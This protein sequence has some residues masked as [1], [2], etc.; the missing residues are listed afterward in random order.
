MSE[1]VPVE[2]PDLSGH[3]NTDPPAGTGTGTG[4]TKV[5][6]H[7][8]TIDL[9]RDALL[10]DFA[11]DLL[12][13]YYM[14]DDEGSPQEAFARAA[15]AYCYGDYDF[16]QRIYDYVSKGWFMFAS[17]VLSNAPRPGD[18]W[19]AL[20]ISCFVA[21]T[22]VMTEAS[23]KNIEDIQPGDM[24]WTHKGRLR[25]VVATRESDS[26]DLYRVIVNGRR[27]PLTVTGNHLLLT[28]LGWVRVDA[29]DVMKHLVAC[30]HTI[31]SPEESHTID[32]L[33]TNTPYTQFKR[34]Q[35]S[36][37]VDVSEDL[38]WALGFWF[39]E[40]SAH[41]NGTVSVT[42][43]DMDPCVRWSNIMSDH[44]GVRGVAEAYRTW[45]TG[46]VCSKTLQEW[47]DAEFGKGCTRKVLAPWI[48]RLP[49]GH[50]KA[51]YDGFYLG[52]GWKTSKHRAVEV[53]N[54][55][56][57]AGVHQ[58]LMKLGIDHTLQ[59]RKRTR[60]PSTVPYNGIIVERNTSGERRHHSIKKGIVFHDGLEYN[61]IQSIEKLD[62][63]AK[64]YD[65]QVEE[66]ESFIAAGVVAHNCFLTY[67]PDSLEGLIE[68]TSELRWLSVKGGGVGGHWSSV[69][70]VSK[71]SPGP[72]PFLK[73][74]DADMTAYRQ[75]TCY[76]PDTEVMTEHGWVRFD[77][78][79]PGVKVA[80]VTPDL[81]VVF[82]L[83]LELVVEDH[84]GDILNVRTPNGSVDLMVT[85]NH[86]M[87]IEQRVRAEGKK[88]WSGVL[89]KRRA[90]EL[91][92][93]ADV[94]FHTSARSSSTGPDV[95][96]PEERFRIAFQ[97]DGH[98]HARGGGCSFHLKK[99]R[100]IERVREILDACGYSY[101]EVDAPDGSVRFYVHAPVTGDKTFAW[102]DLAN[103]SPEWGA[104]FL[105]ELR[106]WDATSRGDGLAGFTYL[107][108]DKG[109]A[110]VVQAVA[111]L[112]GR[113]SRM[114]VREASGTRKDLWK[115]Y[116]RPNQHLTLQKVDVTPS[117]YEGK[118][119]CATV[120]TGMLLVRRSGVVTVC[121]N[122]RKGSYAAYLDVSH[123]DILEFLQ[124][125]LPTGGDPNRKCLNLHNAVNITDDFM[126][127]CVN[128][129]DWHLR[130][131][132]D[133]T[134]RETMPAR[135][136]FQR[137]LEVRFRTGEPYLNFIDTA[138]RALP[139]PLKDKGL[140]I[141]GSNLC[142]AG[143]Q[144]VV[145]DRGLLTARELYEQGGDLTVFDNNLSQKSSAMLL[146]EQ[147]TPV[148]RITLKNGM[149]HT[150]TEYHK[151][152]TDRGD[153]RCDDLV[154]G[155]RVHVQT[156]KGLFG[157]V[158]MEDEAFLLGLYQADGTQHEASLM[159]MIDLWEPDFDLIPEVQERFDRVHHKYGCDT[160]EVRN[161]TGDV[162][163]S[164]P[165]DPAR[166]RDQNTSCSDV[167]KVR[168]SSR[169]FH[170]SGL[171]F[172]KGLV[173][174]WIWSSDEATQWQYI[175]GLFYAD[176]TVN[177]G[178]GKGAPVYLSL[179][180]I[181]K[182]FL[183]DIL[184][185]LRNLGMSASLYLHRKSG[186]VMLPDGKGSH[187]PYE[188]K[189]AWRIVIG[190]K[191]DALAFE[192]A[193]G[194]LTRKGVKIPRRKYRNNS[195][196]VS[197]VVSVEAVGT[198]D[199]FCVNVDSEDHHF[200][201]NGMVTHNCSEIH[202]ATSEDRTAVC[203]LSSLNLARFDEWEGTPLVRDLIR[204]LDNVLQVFI[205]N[206]P[207]EL[208]RARYSATRERSLGLGAMGF[209]SYLQSK[210]LPWESALAKME[211]MRV[212]SHIQSEAIAATEQLAEERGEYPDG[213]GSGRR[214]SHLLAIAPNANSSII[215]GISPSIETWKSN[216][217]THRTRAG[218]HQVRNPELVKILDA[219]IADEAGRERIWSSIT[220]NQG[221][222]QHL[223]DEVITEWE[224]EVFKTA[225]EIDQRWVVGHAAD[226]QPFICQGQSVNLFFPAGSDKNYVLMTHVK[227]WKEGLKALYYLRTSAG[228]SA[229]VVNTKIERVAL[230]DY[231]ETEECLSCQG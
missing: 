186:T 135:D 214:N 207:D 203:C 141:H 98:N 161:G 209:H 180:N 75:G 76:T 173:P 70:A 20:P 204:L 87:V 114:S 13:S 190:N 210:S 16:A 4:Q 147:D 80:Q 93:H 29:L 175:R 14:R 111:A 97:A 171:S 105:D 49:K 109:N 206:A 102:V 28:N 94:R 47:F 156:N 151:V 57:I 179:T 26:S 201:C 127:A 68:H 145:T 217:F 143:H 120:S 51:F 221:S 44:F 24:V 54:P 108:T 19:K 148:F 189:D 83:P 36:T 77:L 170:K 96:T 106:H 202:L 35:V 86:S 11:L 231:V 72:I 38:A 59:L 131:P 118:V 158:S 225:F 227:A 1:T 62:T 122:T 58:I 99:A 159:H 228:V 197:E 8:I 110:D 5:L 132:N 125:R 144:R 71:K 34:N 66:D 165:R 103:I 216:A 188:V 100:K 230:K 82:D 45:H 164:R 18:P 138:N 183:S 25:R 208:S 9:G 150:V 65:I 121:G 23:Y 223:P 182:D 39:A 177:V 195:R 168:L 218:S 215:L 119:Y 178:G 154:I 187:A 32:I 63:H 160:Y 41:D 90:D 163:G 31:Q 155:D 92:R 6:C 129:D 167:R 136:L 64:V 22:P 146:V 112:S 42:H 33:N 184:L 185:I 67:V 153:V 53:S 91:P 69:R 3:N 43:G 133:G 78:L 157:Q 15:V 61:Q 123:P 101:R 152:K 140:K 199:V 174:D 81:D 52:D 139:Q 205:D 126:E 2:S 194:F 128:G 226:R 84:A 89:E 162:V 88:A 104:A 107:T 200:V 176:G 46:R 222:V 213:E 117:P 10:T 229:E 124:I 149:T 21:G 191:T 115:V 40:G 113:T 116:V 181:D 198:D 172:V 55:Q 50:L 166:F 134:I 224:K 192:E 79:D 212:F 48:L 130:D 211:N 56:L 95:L 37:S 196:K 74:V 193:T 220:T 27:T 73:T 12:Q 7:G 60:S 17:P 85:P 137:I 30:D 219:R 169:T 142:V